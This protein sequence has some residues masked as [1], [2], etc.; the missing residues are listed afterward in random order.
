MA[1]VQ[2]QDVLNIYPRS[3][4]VFPGREGDASGGGVVLFVKVV[5]ILVLVYFYPQVS[6]NLLEVWGVDLLSSPFLYGLQNLAKQR[7]TKLTPCYEHPTRKK[8]CS[9][10]NDSPIKES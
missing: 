5:G 7:F 8:N 10:W 6:N 2:V 9:V 4:P 3:V 1:S